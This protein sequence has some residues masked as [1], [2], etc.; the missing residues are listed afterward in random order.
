MIKFDNT[1]TSLPH[2]FYSKAPG[3]HTPLAKVV[4]FNTELANDLNLSEDF[5]LSPSSDER[6]VV[7]DCR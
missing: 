4:V 7:K 3:Q 6:R 2:V 1:Y 5:L